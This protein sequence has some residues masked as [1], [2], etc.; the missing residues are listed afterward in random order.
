MRTLSICLIA[1]CVILSGCQTTSK[2]DEV[3]WDTVL[4]KAEQ[5]LEMAHQVYALWELT[6]ELIGTPEE[7]IAEK[8]AGFQKR[9]TEAE[10]YLTYIR[11]LLDE[12]G[13]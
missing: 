8:R 6:H 13:N 5:S 7:T 11:S 3:D 9:I 4:T 12:K 10:S 1:A 2:F